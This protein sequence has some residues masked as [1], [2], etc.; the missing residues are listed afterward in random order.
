MRQEVRQVID[1]T[2]TKDAFTNKQVG[3]RVDPWAKKTRGY[4]VKAGMPII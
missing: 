2:L 3:N 4:Q 1:A